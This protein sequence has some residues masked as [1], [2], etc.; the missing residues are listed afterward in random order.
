M[1]IT[2]QNLS[3]II[4]SFKSD[5]IIHRCINSIDKEIEIIVVDNSNDTKFKNKIEEQYKNVKCILSPKNIGMGA[6]NNLGIKNTNKEFALI[7]NP[8]VILDKSA[9]DEI[10]KAS[11]EL[12]SFGVI[13]PISD[14]TKYPN[15]KLDQNKNQKF[16]QVDPFKVKTV[17]GYS[18][19]LNLK[20]LKDLNDFNF[21]DENIFLY[22]E[23]DDF[24]KR[25]SST[26]ENIYVVPKSKIHHLGG[27]AVDPKHE[28]EIEL[29]RNWHWMW[30]KFYFN[31]KHYG[32][33]NATLKI[34]HNLISAKIKFFY[35]F[36][37]L[38]NS[39]KKIYQMRLSGLLNSMIGKKSFYRPKL[40][41]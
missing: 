21:F 36:I 26:N 23:N 7:L 32:Y 28:Y 10:I 15:Y 2:K 4:V 37:T 34:L 19:L 40:N 9:I 12:E 29:S 39:K 30:S 25:L 35:Y 17:D 18:M 5:H 11:N 24:C 27:E 20:R 3:V 41:D 33:F 14:K 31:K 8:D 13:A 6:G 16:N 38:N 1:L 22:L